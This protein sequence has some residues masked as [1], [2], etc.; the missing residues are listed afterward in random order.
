MRL[1]TLLENTAVDPALICQHGLSQYLEVNGRRILFDAGPS[2]A[3]VE[4]GE[5]LGVDLGAVDTCILSHGHA[6]GLP[7]FLERNP[8]APSGSSRRRRGGSWGARREICGTSG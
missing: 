1:T 4:N 2:A 3:S 7:A 6:D 5:R 8:T